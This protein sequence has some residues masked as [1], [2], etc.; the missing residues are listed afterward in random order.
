MDFAINILDK[1]NSNSGTVSVTGNSVG[2]VVESTIH[3]GFDDEVKRYNITG[4]ATSNV[5]TTIATVSVTA[6]SNSFFIKKPYLSSSENVKLVKTSVVKSSNVGY[7]SS[8]KNITTYNFDLT[9]VNNKT[10]YNADINVY[11]NYKQSNDSALTSSTSKLI[12]RIAFG[13]SNTNDTSLPS[14][15][16]KHGEKRKITIFGKPGAGFL[17]QI[18]EADEIYNDAGTLLS[19]TETSILD[20]DLYIDTRGKGISAQSAIKEVYSRHGHLINSLSGTIGPNGECSFIQE[21]PSTTIVSKRLNGSMGGD[22]IMDLDDTIGIRLKDQIIM[23][24]IT[25]SSNGTVTPRN[26]VETLNS[27][28]RVLTKNNI[29]AADNARASFARKRNYYIYLEA[30]DTSTLSSSIPTT[31]PTYKLEQLIDPIL[32]IRGSKHANFTIEASVNG[33]T[34]TS[35]AANNY[36]YIYWKGRPNMT[37]EEMKI[38]T[39]ISS[40]HSLIYTLDSDGGTT[41]AI[42]NPTGIF[43]PLEK[44]TNSIITGLTDSSGW[45][46]DIVKVST[47]LSGSGGNDIATIS[48]NLII[49]RFGTEDLELQLDFEK[50]ITIS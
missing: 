34:L 15:I 17:L 42:N 1:I 7:N 25:E 27:S 26:T 50:L 49:N 33:T 20:P 2:T 4:S 43:D 6:R 44:A 46:I 22:K 30:K 14:I 47:V 21:F 29:T 5:V 39:G 28:T 35:A 23:K 13:D 18:N 48:F 8:I 12:N 16:S 45:S 40:T 11:L 3:G 19:V 38:D 41:F 9:Y 36:H 24:E 37:P 10:T 31:T 32:S